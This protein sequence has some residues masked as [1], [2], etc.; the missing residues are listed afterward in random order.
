MLLLYSYLSGCDDIFTSGIYAR[1]KEG[2]VWIYQFGEE[3]GNLLEGESDEENQDDNIKMIISATA[4][5]LHYLGRSDIWYGDGTF[6]VCP[7]LSYQLY[8]F[9]FV[10][11]GAHMRMHVVLYCTILA[12]F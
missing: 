2:E 3:V 6:T 8:T 12:I 5:N 10:S 11:T 4:V 7:S 9:F 1:T